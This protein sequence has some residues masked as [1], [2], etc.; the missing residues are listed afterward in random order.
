MLLN[1]STVHDGKS[2]INIGRA[3]H[4]RRKMWSH[5]PQGVPLIVVVELRHMSALFEQGM[6]ELEAALKLSIKNT[7]S[8]ISYGRS[9]PIRS[10]APE[11][12]TGWQRL[13]LLLSPRPQG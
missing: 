6:T 1:L 2:K 11:A 8:K 4:T 9:T 12:H 13:L 3:S 7:Y 5:D 10:A